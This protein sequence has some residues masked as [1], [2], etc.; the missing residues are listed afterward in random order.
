MGETS[1]NLPGVPKV[2][3]KTAVKWLTQWGSLEALLDNADKITGVVGN[4]LREHLDAVK[5]NR[6]LNRLLRDV[7]LPVGPGDLAVKPLDG[8]AVRDIFARLEFR[9]L[10]PRVFDAF[11]ADGGVVEEARPTAKA[12]APA[13]LDAAALAA[14]AADQ[15]PRSVSRSPSPEPRRRRSAWQSADAAVEAEWSR[16]ARR[17]AGWLASDAPKVFADASPR[18]RR[19]R[20]R[21][22]RW[23]AWRSM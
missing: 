7:E 19:W 20:A 18:S 8:Q 4:N 2:G 17:L 3:E 9:T 16:R 21:A 14:W 15:K 22:S 11:G 23:P 12:P 13:R 1:D 6:A 10:L 5:R